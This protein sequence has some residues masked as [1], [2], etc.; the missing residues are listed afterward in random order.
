M[1]TF[2]PTARSALMCRVRG[3][4]TQPEMIVRRLAHRLGYR[5]RLH[6]RDLPGRPDLVF[7]AR[8]AVI[9]VH[10]CF[11]H[12]HDCSRGARRPMSNTAYWHPKLD[13][14]IERD[15]E[16]REQLEIQGW[17][18]LLLWECEMRDDDQLS[19]RLIS[20]LNN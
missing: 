11:W 12:Q 17:R 14:N 1:D 20:F 18:V 13:R 19:H 5:F 8:R 16:A 10:G 2:N 3:K 7:P 4:D 9:F 6:R 15:R